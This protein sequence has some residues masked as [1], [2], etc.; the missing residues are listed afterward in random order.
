ME[1]VRTMTREYV[2]KGYPNRK[3][4]L[5]AVARIAGLPLSEVIAKSTELGATQDFTGLL[6]YCKQRKYEIEQ[7]FLYEFGLDDDTLELVYGE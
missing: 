3:A 5:E 4:Y 7:S 6:T 2:A 1:N